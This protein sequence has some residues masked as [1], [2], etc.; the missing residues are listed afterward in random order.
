M[1]KFH[2]NETCFQKKNLKT[3]QKNSPEKENIAEI[4][5]KY[6]SDGFP[7]YYH[8]DNNIIILFP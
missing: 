4:A 5:Q 7:K 3:A 1:T 6:P 2:S 8:N